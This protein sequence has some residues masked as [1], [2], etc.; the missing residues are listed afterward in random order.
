ME[1]EN[2][3]DGTNGNDSA[4]V[5]ARGVIEPGTTDKFKAFIAKENLSSNIRFNSPG[6]DVMEALKFGQFLRESNWNTSVG[7]TSVVASVSPIKVKP[8]KSACY[9]ACVYVFAGGVHRT[10]A[11]N[12]VGIH[13][14]YW[15][16]GAS[17]PNDKNF[18]GVDVAN[19]QRLAAQLNEYVRQMG[20]DPRLVT[21]ASSITPWDPIYLLSAAELKNLNLDNSSAPSN[22]TSAVWN[23]EPFQD[24]AVAITRQPQDGAGRRASL[25][26]MCSHSTTDA[27][28]VTL[29]VSDDTQ[30]WSDVVSILNS[31]DD[32][33]FHF[34]FFAIDG[35]NTEYLDGNR[36]FG[37]FERAGNG[38]SLTFAISKQELK[39]VMKAKSVEVAASVVH[40]VE[41]AVGELGGTFSMAGAP[42]V[43]DLA[44][45]N[46]PSHIEVPAPQLQA[47]LRQPY[48]KHFEPDPPNLTGRYP[49]TPTLMNTSPNSSR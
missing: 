32:S 9:S 43:L 22:S 20:I 25:G 15:P 26:I 4:W 7:A 37:R 24:G 46:C 41:R 12:S 11:A 38:L 13:Q 23:V 19:M 10:A 39:L 36:F 48:P 18:S 14:F 44:L 45:K 3:W 29:A 31:T 17:R 28:I 49:T 42:A 34:L 1:F 33:L 2:Q 8:Q 6:G 35:D 27:F 5:L 21:I 47:V 40:M 16:Y 30:D